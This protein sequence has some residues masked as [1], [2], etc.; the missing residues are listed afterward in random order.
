MLPRTYLVIGSN[1]FTGSHI[2]AALMRDH[3]DNQVIGVSRSPEY[4]SIFL[5]YKGYPAGN[6]R[7]VQIDIVRHFE[8]LT[9]LLEEFRPEIVINVAALSEVGL[10]NERPVEYFETNTLSVVRLCNYLR[11]C[12]YLNRYVH[13]S[14]AEVFGSCEQATEETGFRPSTPYAVS[15]AASDMYLNTLMQ[16]H[17]FPVLIIRST[18]VYGKHQQ[19]F[20]IIPRTI[21]YLKLK[22][23]IELHGGGKAIKSFVHISDVVN[24]LMLALAKGGAGTFHFSAPSQK[25]IAEIVMNICQ[26]MQFEFSQSTLVVGERLGQDKAY[27][28]DSKKSFNELGWSPQ[29]NFSEGLDDV[30]DWVNINWETIIKQPLVYIHKV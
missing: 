3:P 25:T 9:S 6:F 27:I 24:G 21:I 11:S 19:L 16:N 8:A 28:I 5:P 4:Q 30:I 10:S 26:K 7:F 18:N 22:K 29:I 20:K 17:G 13:I 12:K 1:C 2:V 14:S 23:M 15:K